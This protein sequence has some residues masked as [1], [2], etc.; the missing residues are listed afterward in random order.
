MRNLTLNEELCF[1]S[2]DTLIFLYSIEYM[3]KECNHSKTSKAEEESNTNAKTNQPTKYHKAECH[4]QTNNS[5]HH[6]T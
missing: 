6:Y 5:L 2:N 1:S 3:N 4:H